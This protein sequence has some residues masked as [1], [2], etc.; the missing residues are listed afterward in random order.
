MKRSDLLF[1][2]V[3]I[4]LFAPFFLSN[5][6]YQW[7]LRFNSAHP[8]ITAFTKFAILATMGEMLGLRI[9]SKQYNK[10]GFGIALRA[11]VWGFLGI[12]LY[13]A[14]AVFASGT[15]VLM[16]KLGYTTSQAFTNRLLVAFSISTLMN[17]FYAPVLMTFHKITDMHILSSQ[18]K[19]GTFFASFP[20]GKYFVN[21]DWN[22]HWNF[23]LKKTIPL[24][25]IPAQTINFM[26]P[27][28]FRILI[29][30]LYS[31]V[32]GVLLSIAGRSAPKN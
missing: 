32:L 30:A 21:L 28:D 1:L 11:L 15:P 7:F 27:E 14:F 29:A 12:T 4:A 3:F 19:P 18:G 17:L 13:M 5:D 24:F 25:W 23:V 10:K 20:M 9:R 31:I 16:G 2:L 22:T 8:L 6:L 26:M